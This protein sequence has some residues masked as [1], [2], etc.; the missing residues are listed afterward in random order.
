SPDDRYEP[1][2]LSN[3][4]NIY[5]A[6]ALKRI[7]GVGNVQIFGERRYAMRLW[8]NPSELAA[9]DLTMADVVAAV[10][11]QNL[12]AAVGQIG[13]QPTPK[14]DMIQLDLEAQGRLT[15]A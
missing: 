13:Q 14:S 1:L 3:Y 10:N 8:I 5:L 7:N 2:F 12:Q 4:A 9:H 6:D 11:Q 15:D